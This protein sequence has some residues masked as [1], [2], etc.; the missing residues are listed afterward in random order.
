MDKSKILSYLQQDRTDAGILVIRLVIGLSMAFLHGY[1]KITGG[2]ELWARIGGSMENLGISFTPVFWGF[3]A[4]V[5]EFFASLAIVLG[6]L[7]RP[8]AAMLIITMFVAAVNHLS[9]PADNPRSGLSGASHALEFMAVYVGLF[10]TGAG[11][12][13][14]SALW[15]RGE[16]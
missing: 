4:A 9:L 7:F 12:Y 15:R 6:I 3:M 10:L 5:A 14:L 11:R 8:A 1:G 13:K 2:P 16:M